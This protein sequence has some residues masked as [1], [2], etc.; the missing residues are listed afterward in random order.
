MVLVLKCHWES[1][2]MSW[3]LT[4]IVFYFSIFIVC[5]YPP[6]LY[7][8]LRVAEKKRPGNA[9][10]ILCLGA[11][12]GCLAVF[13]GDASQRESRKSLT[14]QMLSNCSFTPGIR[15]ER[16]LQMFFRSQVQVLLRSLSLQLVVLAGFWIFLT[17]R[18]S[19][20]AF[21]S[22]RFLMKLFPLTYLT[23]LSKSCCFSHLKICL[24]SSPAELFTDD[25]RPALI[26]FCGSDEDSV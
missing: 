21:G 14:S 5:S 15:P 20:A 13:H 22:C 3:M 8:F 19:A 18:V 2:Q 16:E 1:L 23:F 6:L 4:L 26:D 12:A 24:L 10:W 17:V 25:I 7:S 11:G 9:T